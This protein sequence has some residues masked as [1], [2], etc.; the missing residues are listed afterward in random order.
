MDNKMRRFLIG[1][2]GGTLSL[3]V[4]LAILAGCP[5]PSSGGGGG[6]TTSITSVSLDKTEI[7]LTLDPP[8]TQ[9]LTATVSP[10]NA[11]QT[12]NWSSSD[13]AVASVSNSGLVT[14]KS[15][16][17]A[18]I[19][20]ASA[21]DSTK[22]EVCIVTVTQTVIPLTGIS[23]N[24]TS[25]SLNPNGIYTLVVTYTPSNTTQ[26]GVT[27]SS[28]NPAV[29]M[30]NN[31]TGQ[32]TALSVGSAIITATSTVDSSKKVSCTVTVTDTVIPLTGIS[33]NET[34]NMEI[35]ESKI[36]V[37]TYTPSDTT[38]KGVEWTSSNESV[39]TVANGEV[40]ALSAGSAV[41]T[42]T[43][44]AVKTLTAS[45]TITVNP[46]PVTSVTLNK[47][48]IWIALTQ[49]Q[50]GE[51]KATIIPSTANQ[52]VRWESNNPA[53][54]TV[55]NNGVVTPRSVGYAR[56]IATAGSISA[57]CE[58]NVLLNTV[59]LGGIN[60]SENT[61]ALS[62]GE[63]RTLTVSYTPYDTT[64][65][66]DITWTSNNPA[67]VT[68]DDT[69]QIT[70]VSVG[71]A[72]ITARS[73]G[74]ITATCTV[75]VIAPPLTSIS[76]D[77]PTLNLNPG[78][79][80]TLTVI[81]TPYDTTQKSVTWTSNRPAVATVD[82][83]GVVTAVGNG[84]AIITVRSTLH[85]TIYATCTVTV[86]P[87]VIPITG[88]ILNQSSLNLERNGTYTL[89]GIFDPPNTTQKGIDWSSSD[90]TVATVN[91]NGVVT[92][93][94]KN[95][96]ATITAKSKVNSSLTATCTV[97]VGDPVPV[98]GINSIDYNV[99]LNPGDTYNLRLSYTPANTTQ[100]GVTWASENPAIATVDSSGQVRALSSGY[101]FIIA[102]STVNIE[103]TARI[104][105]NVAFPPLTG[106]SLSQTSLNLNKGKM[107]ALTV[108]YIPAGTEQTGVNW[109]SSN[110]SVA[111][112][113]YNGL[114]RAVGLGTAVI[115]AISSQD[116]LLTAT[117][118]VTVT[119]PSLTG[120][121][122]NMSSLI[123]GYNGKSPLAVTYIPA[124]T[125]QTG[126]NWTS[127]N[128]AVTVDGNGLVTAGTTNGS[129]TITATSTIDPT[130]KAT[131]IVTVT[132]TGPDINV[133][134]DFQDEEIT[135]SDPVAT[136]YSIYINAPAGY[137]S[138]L[139]YID[140]NYGIP[141]NGPD[142][143]WLEIYTS[144]YNLGKHTV[145]V[146]V[147]KADGSHFSKTVHFTVGY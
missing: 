63:S 74:G 75:S 90:S 14:P 58:V 140:D 80:E 102:R 45:C 138:Y 82:S 27:W 135:L 11:D 91:N 101:V 20:A 81:Y 112:V 57:F 141:S 8:Q 42:A 10:P 147:E 35:G 26:T 99:Q 72:A 131:C 130:I 120:I 43:S 118:T 18:I 128:P 4:I 115:T 97:T 114:V 50:T 119:P 68:V 109:T 31:T 76:L 12:V 77:R 122:L 94:N 67:V 139:W 144:S 47:T 29:A 40:T 64:D 83:N 44:T 79:I 123:L 9:L 117:C 39:A 111:T 106:I 30:V 48:E 133:N 16:G 98:T 33:L 51:L 3:L 59:P 22:K 129:A 93:R 54:A 95:G 55:N 121:K 85:N 113:D 36:L 56:I 62:K 96:T 89:M 61:L 21:V 13:A 69:G 87:V 125:A 143:T 1:G 7:R 52:T 88:I 100:M 78:G 66:R 108:T 84:D 38:Q 124:D 60:L 6:T 137:V 126:V 132:D 146:I 24:E 92:A 145:T 134:L 34:P 41:I 127:N 17:L 19:T 46:P 53:V 142:D 116:S 136:G 86:S 103:L 25:L 37:V 65:S 32:V 71:S 23:L 2:G 73:T 104:Q 15:A 49:G 5:N 107:Q 28:S 110:E 105:I 70:A